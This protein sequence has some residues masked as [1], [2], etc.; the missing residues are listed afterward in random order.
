[1]ENYVKV[2]TK[3]SQDSQPEF[4][5]KRSLKEGPQGQGGPKEDTN[6]IQPG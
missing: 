1:M 5:V 6:V 4:I 2:P 3:Q